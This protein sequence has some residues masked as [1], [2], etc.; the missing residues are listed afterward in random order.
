MSRVRFNKEMMSIEIDL[1]SEL[2]SIGLEEQCCDQAGML[3]T[4]F[5]LAG[6][7]WCTPEILFD[8]MRCLDETCILVHGEKAQSLFSQFAAGKML[9][10]GWRK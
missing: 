5:R 2:Y 7:R 10:W 8:F 4:I 9:K 6:Q 3:D 1:G